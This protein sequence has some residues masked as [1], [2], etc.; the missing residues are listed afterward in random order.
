MESWTRS[1]KDYKS[2]GKQPSCHNDNTRLKHHGIVIEYVSGSS[3]FMVLGTFMLV[4]MQP[5]VFLPPGEVANLA[6]FHFLSHVV[7][8]CL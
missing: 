1:I 2:K 3:F 5:S 4:Y 8:N 6:Y 7:F